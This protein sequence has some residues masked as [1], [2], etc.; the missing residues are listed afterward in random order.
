MAAQTEAMLDILAYPH[1]FD[2]IFA[3]TPYEGLLVLRLVNRAVKDRVDAQLFKHVLVCTPERAS[4]LI[5]L[6]P[7]GDRLPLVP[8]DLDP[9]PAPDHRD[10]DDPIEEYFGPLQEEGNETAAM[11]AAYFSR[12]AQLRHVRTLDFYSAKSRIKPLALGLKG[13]QVVRSKPDWHWERHARKWRVQSPTFVS[14]LDLVQSWDEL[15]DVGGWSLTFVDGRLSSPFSFLIPRTQHAVL[16]LHYTSERNMLPTRFRTLPDLESLT[17]VWHD[18]AGA[19]AEPNKLLHV[20]EGLPMLQLTLVGLEPKNILQAGDWMAPIYTR[21]DQLGTPNFRQVQ[22]MT[23]GRWK[24]ENEPLITQSGLTY[25]QPYIP[26]NQDFGWDSDEEAFAKK[27]Y[28]DEPEDGAIDGSS[29]VE[30]DF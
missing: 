30:S 20:V 5:L 13:L 7:R 27:Y 9:A 4:G 22:I 14:Y 19:Q 3:L 16:H 11:D 6:S 8:W 12:M 2:Q 23:L 18:A 28:C 29:D 24:A 10:Y 15:D 1:I 21:L 17:L 25:K 26:I